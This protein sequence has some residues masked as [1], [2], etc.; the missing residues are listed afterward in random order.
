MSDGVF[1]PRPLLPPNRRPRY[2]PSQ[3]PGAT[4]SGSGSMS[5]SG[6]ANFAAITFS[7]SSEV[8]LGGSVQLAT[9]PRFQPE[10]DGFVFAGAAALRTTAGLPG[11]GAIT[12]SASANLSTGGPGGA[13]AG[14]GGIQISGAGALRTTARLSGSG[15]LT[16]SATARLSV[17]IS[18]PYQPIKQPYPRIRLYDNTYNNGSSITIVTQASTLAATG[19]S[20]VA[21]LSQGGGSPPSL[22]SALMIMAIIT[23]NAVT[24]TT[25]AGWTLIGS[26]NF[27]TAQLSVYRRAGTSSEPANY[28]WNFSGSTEAQSYFIAYGGVDTSTP[29]D[30]TATSSGNGS[31]FTTGTTAATTQAR[32]MA[33]AFYV[34]NRGDGVPY[35]VTTDTYATVA[36]MDG[37]TNHFLMAEKPL[38]AT[39]AQSTSAIKPRNAVDYVSMLITLKEAAAASTTYFNPI[40]ELDEAEGRATMRPYDLGD[41]EIS[42]DA[43][44]PV[45]SRVMRNM[46]VEFWMPAT[47]V[48]PGWS[49]GWFIVRHIERDDSLP[50][51]RITLSGPD[52][53][54]LISNRA[55]QSANVE[56][57]RSNP[58]VNK[59]VENWV[60]GYINASAISVQSGQGYTSADN[61][62]GFRLETSSGNRGTV[63]TD[64]P[65]NTGA[66]LGDVISHLYATD[67]L[68]WRIVV[69]N[70]GSTSAVMEFQ[71]YAGTDRR[72]G[73]SSEAVF[74]MQWDTATR[75]VKFEDAVSAATAIT[76]LAGPND[77]STRPG[78]FVYD[79]VSKANWGLLHSM[80]DISSEKNPD[81]TTAIA[82]L[83]QR[84]PK[85][86]L[87][88]DP[89]QHQNLRANVHYSLLD[90]V[91]GLTRSGDRFDGQIVSWS[92]QVS[93]RGPQSN[94]GTFTLPELEG[95]NVE[96]VVREFGDW[97]SL[98]VG[99]PPDKNAGAADD[100]AANR[101]YTYMKD[102][103]ASTN[104]LNA[105]HGYTGGPG[106]LNKLVGFTGDVT[107][108]QI[109][110]DFTGSASD[111]NKT[112]GAESAS[113][114][115]PQNALSA[116]SLQTTPVGAQ[117][118]ATATS[119]IT[120]AEQASTQSAITALQTLVD[121]LS[122]R[123]NNL[124]N[125]LKGT[126]GARVISD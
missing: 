62:A 17:I 76:A 25:P 50:Y 57:N 14:S 90:N 124:S 106:D 105:V 85:T 64:A 28:T 91:T 120:A 81:A 31:T 53:R 111:L 23:T 112:V 65:A 122:A 86:W 103:I 71:T 55:V 110:A 2:V 73:G 19:S 45:A 4:L 82:Y 83:K 56:Y 58:P 88:I 9:L 104:E 68:G 43:R 107:D 109:I 113:T 52:L 39:G 3:V 70:A 60:R 13:I 48:D 41:F 33:L 29:V 32:E 61:I 16:V 79:A 97:M 98:V 34:S 22:A 36:E 26:S 44:D 69:L 100:A 102:L 78:Y 49:F 92:V 24:I 116:A 10:A 63:Y 54:G 75:V 93:T 114:R 101:D 115:N 84:L 87:E 123:V 42:F 6:S 95:V 20:Y 27:N 30:R 126:S 7:G 1:R 72:I 35:P 47:A 66:S 38:Q 8:L 121:G 67:Q 74:C 117:T 94:F 18:P 5:F 118:V 80:V 119:V 125:A 108:L 37:F 21:N 12:F 99:N 40:G 89:R 46:L 96:P 77:S 51:P 11:S 59:S 15:T